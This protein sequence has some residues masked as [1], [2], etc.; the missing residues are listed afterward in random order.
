[1]PAGLEDTNWH[2]K[3]RLTY[4]SEMRTKNTEMQNLNTTGLK[5]S[6]RLALLDLGNIHFKFGFNQ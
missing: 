5:D 3:L 1:M 4:E 2:K 6:I